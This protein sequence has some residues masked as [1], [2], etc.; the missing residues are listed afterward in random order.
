MSIFAHCSVIKIFYNLKGKIKT[1]ILRITLL[2]CRKQRKAF[3]SET[4]LLFSSK[5]APSMIPSYGTIKLT[6]YPTENI[7]T[8]HKSLNNLLGDYFI[9]RLSLFLK[10]IDIFQKILL[11]NCRY[12]LFYDCITFVL[13]LPLYW[14]VKK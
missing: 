13:I 11:Q 5:S 1:I 4:T 8:W 10:S 6:Q 12:M 3:L 14:V 9:V 2:Y 7:R